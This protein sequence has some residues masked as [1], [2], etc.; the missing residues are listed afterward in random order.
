MK[1]SPSAQQPSGLGFFGKISYDT[2]AVS[3]ESDG[4]SDSGG[5][6]VDAWI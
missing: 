4:D 2:A 5:P 3:S 6:I 1:L